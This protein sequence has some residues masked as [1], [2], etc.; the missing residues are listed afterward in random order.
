MEAKRGIGTPVQ[1]LLAAHSIAP[2]NASAQHAPLPLEQFLRIGTHIARALAEFHARNGVHGHLSPANIVFFPGGNAEIKGAPA[3]SSAATTVE[4]W[5]YQAPEQTGRFER[6]VDARSDLY[7]L[8]VVL[9]EL[10]VGALPFK[11]TDALS[12]IHSHVAKSPRPPIVALPAIPQ[13]VSD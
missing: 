4:H 2:A 8:G 7:V 3:T 1:T 5:I 11:A 6:P 10:L 9:Y 12:W 13:T